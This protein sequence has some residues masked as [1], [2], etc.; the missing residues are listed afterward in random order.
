MEARPSTALSDATPT[1]SQTQIITPDEI[2]DQGAPVLRLNLR[3]TSAE[4]KVS[5]N[6]DTVD[7][8][9][10]GR[11]KSKCCCIYQKP[12]AFGESSS[13]EDDDE[14]EH[15]FGH[16]EK[17]KKNQKKTPGDGENPETNGHGSHDHPEPSNIS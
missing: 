11:K 1:G 13:E 17:K 2:P 5:W 3:R 10:M 14:C 8:E 6:S 9:N 12:L 4:K 16:V 15:C 7:N